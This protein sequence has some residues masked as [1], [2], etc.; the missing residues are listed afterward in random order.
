VRESTFDLVLFYHA[1]N[2]QHDT[3]Y[4]QYI[5]W[6]KGRARCRANFE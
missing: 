2:L 5:I 4:V 1:V 3:I 6:V